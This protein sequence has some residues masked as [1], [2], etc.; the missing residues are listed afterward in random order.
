MRTLL[1]CVA[2]LI[3]APAVARADGFP[4]KCNCDANRTD[5]G[6]AAGGLVLLAGVAYG[7][8]RR[9]KG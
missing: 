8:G 4:L 3:A 5:V 2:A 9:R 1:L 7:L 6:G